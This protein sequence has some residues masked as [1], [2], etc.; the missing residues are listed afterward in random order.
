MFGTTQVLAVHVIAQGAVG[1][2]LCR[3]RSQDI[4]GDEKSPVTALPQ[5]S[6]PVRAKGMHAACSD[7]QKHL[8]SLNTQLPHC[9]KYPPSTYVAVLVT[10]LAAIESCRSIRALCVVGILFCWDLSAH[11]LAHPEHCMRTHWALHVQ[12]CMLTNN[13]N[14]ILWERKGHV[15]RSCHNL[16][17]PL[18]TPPSLCI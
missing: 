1:L 13:S 2:S 5:M 14:A 12:A 17:L 4:Q 7:T 11:G 8:G 3:T 18:P 16:K 9:A 10:C 15:V 6:L